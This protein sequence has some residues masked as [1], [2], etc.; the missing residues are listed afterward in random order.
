M[1]L[2]VSL[3]SDPSIKRG[4]QQT[5]TA[6][7]PDWFKQG[8]ASLKYADKAEILPGYV[9][10]ADGEPKGLLL[11]KK[12]DALAAEIFWLAVDP[13]Y[14]R[15]G[16]GRSLVSA[17]CNTALAD[18]AKFLLVWTHHARTNDKPYEAT[19]Q[20]YE[21]I[22]FRYLAEEHFPAS[23]ENPLALYVRLLG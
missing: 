7:L 13:D 4:I 12:H 8:D 23:L 1:A 22:G 6:L 20:F 17:A 18:G 9:A 2:T 3:E 11:Y 10:R 21:R 19:R 5:L 16:V 15:S 14:H